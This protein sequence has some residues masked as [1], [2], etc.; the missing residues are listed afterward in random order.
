MDFRFFTFLDFRF[1]DISG[2]Q[3]QY[4][5]AFLR[6]IIQWPSNEHLME[7]NGSSK[8][9]ISQKETKKVTVAM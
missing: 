9:V 7:K 3:H 4:D 8:I 5:D 6:L 2:F 1:L